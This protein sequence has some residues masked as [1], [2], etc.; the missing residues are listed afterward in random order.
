LLL[1][2]KIRKQNGWSQSVLS[3]RS[4]VHVS[5]ISNVERGRLSPWPGQR[6]KIALALEWPEDRADELFEVVDHESA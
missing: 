5:T 2:T 6:A 3:H 4:G 1:M